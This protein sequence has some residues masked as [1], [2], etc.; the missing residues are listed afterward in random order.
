MGMCL[1][2][3]VGLE[4]ATDLPCVDVGQHHVQQDEHRLCVPRTFDAGSSCGRRH[5]VQAGFSANIAAQFRLITLVLDHEH[6]R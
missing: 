4:A 6:P 1:G 2:P 3:V 5:R